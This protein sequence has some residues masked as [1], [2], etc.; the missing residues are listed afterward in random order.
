MIDGAMRLHD[1]LE[2]VGVSEPLSA[3]RESLRTL[4]VAHREAFLFENVSIQTGGGVSVA[5]EDIERKFLDE[6]RG[7]YCFEHNTL[8][9]HCGRSASRSQRCSAACG[10]GRPNAGVARTWS[11]A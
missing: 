7:G 4:H 8:F 5:L 10:E 6:G 3:D 11:C 1:Y 2:R 9:S